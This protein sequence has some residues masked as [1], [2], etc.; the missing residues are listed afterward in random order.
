MNTTVEIILSKYED[1]VS[2]LGLQLREFLLSNLKNI[3][4]QPDAAASIIGYNFG[5]GYKDLICTIIPSRKGIKLGLYKGSELPDPEKLLTG[6]GKVHKFVEIKSEKDI[7]SPALLNLLKQA[8]K[9][10]QM[11]IDN[12]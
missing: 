9:A 12:K 6:S 4:E 8:L 7:R 3:N 1:K 10:H 11:R 5:T 2:E